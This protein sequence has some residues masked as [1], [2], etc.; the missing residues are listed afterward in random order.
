MNHCI[1][2]LGSNVAPYPTILAALEALR[3]VDAL[4]LSLP[5]QLTPTAGGSGKPLY[6]NQL[7]SL[8]TTLSDNE[9]TVRFKELEKALGRTPKDKLTGRVI[10]DI[11]LVYFNNQ[12]LKPFEAALPYVVEGLKFF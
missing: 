4:L 7:V 5:Q 11:D 1:I 2:L 6:M 12:L 8:K 10:I 3:T 9:L